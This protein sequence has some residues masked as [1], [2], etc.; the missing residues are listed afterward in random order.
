MQCHME[1]AKSRHKASTP[2]RSLPQTVF[3]CLKSFQAERWV[4]EC[5][6]RL[7]FLSG[8]EDA[9]QRWVPHVTTWRFRNCF[10]SLGTLLFLEEASP[11]KARPEWWERI[12]FSCS[13]HQKWIREREPTTT[14][15]AFPI[16]QCLL[17]GRSENLRLRELSIN[18]SSPLLKPMANLSN[19]TMMTDQTKSHFGMIETNIYNL[20]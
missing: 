10:S 13:L 11:E 5:G 6:F 7:P 2:A 1:L 9:P 3:R 18:R 12:L 17:W 14:N 16:D 4:H 19:Y 8:H 15:W 20:V